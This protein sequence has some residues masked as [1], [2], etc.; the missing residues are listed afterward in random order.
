MPHVGGTVDQA[1]LSLEGGEALE[2][3]SRCACGRRVRAGGRLRIDSPPGR[4]TRI[5]AEIPCE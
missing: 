2:G 1:Q 3:I 5:T 4:G